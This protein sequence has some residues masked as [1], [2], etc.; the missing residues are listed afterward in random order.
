M[1][2][3]IL[4]QHPAVASRPRVSYSTPLT[5]QVPASTPS[6]KSRANTDLLVCSTANAFGLDEAL[7]VENPFKKLS[8]SYLQ[9]A[10]RNSTPAKD[11]PAELVVESKQLEMETV[12]ETVSSSGSSYGN[13]PP[14]FNKK[15]EMQSSKHRNEAPN[16]NENAGEKAAISSEKTVKNREEAKNANDS[17]IEKHSPKSNIG[18]TDTKTEQSKLVNGDYIQVE[19]QNE[20]LQTMAQTSSGP[21][22]TKTVNADSSTDEELANS[23]DISIGNKGS[24]SS[25]NEWI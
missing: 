22:T 13:L 8:I 4:D 11:L 23:L 9:V 14:N 20:L 6:K 2:K 18:K 7:T 5:I 12:L 10:H 16:R 19:T 24:S 3:S 15:N 25:P 1:E 21:L 17:A